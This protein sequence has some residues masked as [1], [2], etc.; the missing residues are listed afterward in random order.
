MLAGEMLVSTDQCRVG[1][2]DVGMCGGYGVGKKC[3][4][5]SVASAYATGVFWP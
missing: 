5:I 3:P 1:L 4:P 2:R